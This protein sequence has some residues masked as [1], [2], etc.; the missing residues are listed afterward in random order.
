MNKYFI[1]FSD[2][3]TNEVYGI[4]RNTKVSTMKS[5]N[6]KKQIDPM[7]IKVYNDSAQPLFENPCEINEC[8]DLCLPKVGGG[9]ICS[10]RMN[11]TLGPDNKTCFIKSLLPKVVKAPKI[12]NLKFNSIGTTAELSWESESNID[13]Y[14]RIILECVKLRRC[15][16]E[17]PDNS[18]IIKKTFNSSA[19]IDH[20]KYGADYNISIYIK[21]T[22]LHSEVLSTLDINYKTPKF[23]QEVELSEQ[24]TAIA[25][26]QPVDDCEIVGYKYQLAKEDDQST[27]QTGFTVTPKVYL[28]G[29]IKGTRYKLKVW[30]VILNMTSEESLNILFATQEGK[31]EIQQL[32]VYKLT[33][34]SIGLRWKLNNNLKGEDLSYNLNY[35]TKNDFASVSLNISSI[36][37][38]AWADKYCY[39]LTNLSS[40]WNHTI[41]IRP[42]FQSK[43]GTP[44]YISAF[45]KEKSPGKPTFL[46]GTFMLSNSVSLVWGIPDFIN[47]QL[48]SFLI[49]I[50][51]VDKHLNKHC[52]QDFPIMEIKAFPSENPSYETE[53]SGIEPASTY[54]ISVYAKTIYI[55]PPQSL[56]MYTKPP[57]MKVSCLPK[58]KQSSVVWLPQNN[59]GMWPE[60]QEFD[61]LIEGYMLLALC[62]NTTCNHSGILDSEINQEI[63]GTIGTNTF[64]VA[65]YYKN[66]ESID[67]T[68][69]QS[70][71]SKWGSVETFQFVKGHS[72]KLLAVQ[73]AR[74]IQSYRLDVVLSNEFIY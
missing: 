14:Y 5:F 37:C 2:W 17:C 23:L 60:G 52:C 35:S 36:R 29:L 32:A 33:K 10:C 55:G 24:L 18:N 39:T 69:S 19:I 4:L 7:G 74:Y 46:N 1:F 30:S 58:I 42:V 22:H 61:T 27:L 68:P 21:D 70:S 71:Q 49:S 26:W 51:E 3:N 41:S 40:F 34:N 64:F 59:S 48:R 57:S 54:E 12:S 63:I 73:V 43:L 20:L 53:I 11:Y 47:G 50:E 15:N 62:I 38:T 72:Y 31:E 8:S 13:D 44:M 56:T 65:Q 28:D 9:K 67:L 45:T 6:I 16:T 25:Y 66:E